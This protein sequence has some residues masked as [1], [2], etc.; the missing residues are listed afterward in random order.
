MTLATVGIAKSRIQRGLPEFRCLLFLLLRCRV[1]G[2][3][4]RTR[5]SP[6]VHG[7][8]PSRRLVAHSGPS[9]LPV[10]FGEG[11]S[12]GGKRR[13]AARCLPSFAPSLV[14]FPVLSSTPCHET[15]G[16]YAA[17]PPGLRGPGS[18]AGPPFRGVQPSC[19]L[20][21]PQRTVGRGRGVG[22]RGA[23]RDARRDRRRRRSARVP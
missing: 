2:A 4:V 16:R 15:V 18:P 20:E 5:E 6:G 8:G 12:R 3:P 11:A 1:T 13:K 19:P 10:T 9:F 17:L 7:D 23:P 22:R 21:H 14:I